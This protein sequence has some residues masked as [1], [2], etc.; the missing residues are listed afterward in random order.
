MC[1]DIYVYDLGQLRTTDL[2]L[3]A[4]VLTEV[5]AVATGQVVSDHAEVVTLP[6][7]V[8]LAVPRSAQ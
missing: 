6:F 8:T 1:M 3:Q 7:A 2:V 5:V 4:R